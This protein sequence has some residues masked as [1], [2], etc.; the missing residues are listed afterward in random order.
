MQEANT[1]R[2]ISAIIGIMAVTGILGIIG[3][4]FFGSNLPWGSEDNKKPHPDAQT[5]FSQYEDNKRKPMTI[6]AGIDL[7][8]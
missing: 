2:L 1:H 7:P 5:R 6:L 8:D 3:Y 4:F